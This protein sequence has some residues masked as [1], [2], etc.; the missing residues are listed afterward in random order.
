VLKEILNHPLL[1]K[2]FSN[3]DQTSYLLDQSFS[4][5][6]AL[7]CTHLYHSQNKNILVIS[8]EKEENDLYLDLEFFCKRAHHRTSRLGLSRPQNRAF[9]RDYRPKKCRFNGS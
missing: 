9:Q 7:L 1:K 8:S 2:H 6:T 5:L 4:S 3:L